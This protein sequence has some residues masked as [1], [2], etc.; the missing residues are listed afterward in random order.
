MFPK[1]LLSTHSLNEI[2][3]GLFCNTD[4]HKVSTKN[5][6]SKISKGSCGIRYDL[7]ND[8]SKIRMTKLNNF[9]QNYDY[10]KEL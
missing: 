3:L 6:F 1:Q 4:V 2:D 7:L 5:I 8:L 10:S 9:P